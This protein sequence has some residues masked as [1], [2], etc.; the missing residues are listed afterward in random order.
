MARLSKKV[1]ITDPDD[2]ALAA[3]ASAIEA[4]PRS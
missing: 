2:E 3:T 4:G 1:A